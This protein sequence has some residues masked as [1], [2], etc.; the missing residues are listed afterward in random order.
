MSNIS[1][2]KNNFLGGVRPNQF[3][4]RF[5]AVPEAAGLG[6]PWL[7]TAMSC[8]AAQIPSSVVGNVDVPFLG[9][10]L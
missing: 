1:N 7:D 9:R 2:F 4:V 8:K 5:Y 3:Y 10:Q 6:Q